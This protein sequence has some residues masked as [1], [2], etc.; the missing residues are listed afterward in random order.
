MGLGVPWGVVGDFNY[1]LLSPSYSLFE[2]LSQVFCSVALFVFGDIGRS[3]FGNHPATLFS[4][5]GTEVDNVVG[6]LDDIEV[7]LDDDNRIALVYQLV[8]YFDKAADILEM[9][10]RSRL[11]ENIERASRFAL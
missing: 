2:I 5:L 7:V 4:T 11:V 10:A 8:K 9:E 3:T 1:S 6:N